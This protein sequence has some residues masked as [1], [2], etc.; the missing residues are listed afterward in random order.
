MQLSILLKNMVLKVFFG[1][2]VRILRVGIAQAVTFGVY[3]N[4]INIMKN[5]YKY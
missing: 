1:L 5:I 2:K 4:Y 3:E